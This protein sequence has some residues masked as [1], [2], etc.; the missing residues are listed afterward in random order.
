MGVAPAR[1]AGLRRTPT[2]PLLRAHASM[3][4]VAVHALSIAACMR[5]SLRGP[6]AFPQPASLWRAGMSRA[7]GAM[8]EQSSCSGSIAFKTILQLRTRT[9][10][11]RSP[12][13]C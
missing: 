1:Y 11:R 6:L 9:S 13:F 10:F 3:T 4:P 12:A 2:P 7:R 5:V 8:P